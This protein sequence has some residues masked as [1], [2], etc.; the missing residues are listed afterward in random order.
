MSD[1]VLPPHDEIK[2]STG[3]FISRGNGFAIQIFGC[4]LV[5]V[6]LAVWHFYRGANGPNWYRPPLAHGDGPDYE[7]IAYSLS[8][9]DGFQF[10]WQSES[11]QKPYREDVEAA[12][13]SQ[14][15]RVDWPGPT[16]SRPPLYPAL[17]ALVYQ[18]VPRGPIGF[19]TVRSISI[20]CTALAGTLAVCLA[21]DVARRIFSSKGLAL[22]AALS[23][24][25]L[26]ILDRTIRGYSIDFLTEPLAML[27]CTVLLWSGLK[28]QAGHRQYRWFVCVVIS[29]TALILT[30]SM[31]VF[32]L[33]GVAILIG[34]SSERY[35]V[36]WGL[37]LLVCVAVCLSPWWIRNC[38]V[39]KRL[40]PL[41][42]QGAA[43]LSGG[44]CDE[45]LADHGNWHGRVENELQREI[46]TIPESQ[47]WTQAQRE[48]VLADMAMER[49][50]EWIID[51]QHEIP[52][53]MAMRVATH[54][55]PFK[56]TSLLWRLGIA[57]GWLMLLSMRRPEWVWVL[58]LPMISTLAVAVLYETGGRFLV[59]LYAI[60]YM[61]AGLGIAFAMSLFFRSPVSL[62]RKN[63]S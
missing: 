22:V 26:A 59:P 23:T 42:G 43:S 30:R 44:Y 55:G 38:I 31:M 49:T 32:W 39:M 33:P 61:T 50:K 7:S 40:M 13:Y 56:G 25:A 45:S 2:P 63:G 12:P 6:I 47:G 9:W 53:L 28:W 34:L 36:R 10:A 51:H 57:T 16:T 20:L 37:L 8:Q 19:S 11:W 1:S 24:L 52:K 54:W 5:F 60:L 27:L 58:G 48:V 14:L 15:D 3:G 46:D 21:F 35:R 62:C 41:G 18:L 17:I 29:L 4:F